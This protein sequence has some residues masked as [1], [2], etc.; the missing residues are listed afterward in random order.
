MSPS[1]LPVLMNLS[2]HPTGQ[3]KNT[4]LSLSPV[5]S[6]ALTLSIVPGTYT[7]THLFTSLYT[8]LSDYRT[9]LPGLWTTEESSVSRNFCPTSNSLTV[10]SL[11][12]YIRAYLVVQGLRVQCGGHWY[13]PWSGK[14]THALEQLSLCATTTEAH[15]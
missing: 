14:I 10:L 11:K 4:F 8:S 2:I 6:S 1:L 7:C 9:T 15:S 5:S 3:G 12:L 13:D